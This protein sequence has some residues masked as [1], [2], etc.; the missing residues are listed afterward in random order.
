MTYPNEE[1]ARAANAG[2]L[3]PDLSCVVKARLNHEDYIFTLLTGYHE[4][5]AGLKIRE[6]L[7]YNP[8][9]PGGAIS[10][11]RALYDGV[12]EYED[13][14]NCTVTCDITSNCTFFHVHFQPIL[15][16]SLMFML[17][18]L[19]A[20]IITHVHFQPIL[21]FFSDGITCPCSCH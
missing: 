12:V 14:K 7:H 3:P 13:G 8:Y 15:Q 21:Q 18:S 5:P 20:H 10:M 1:A 19:V 11:A 4:P 16:F 9:F 6:G 17:M 2:A